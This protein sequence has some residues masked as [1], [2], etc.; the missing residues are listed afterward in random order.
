[1]LSAQRILVLL[2]CLLIGGREVY[3]AG[4]RM[5]DELCSDKVDCQNHNERLWTLPY[6][7]AEEL[8]DEGED[9]GDDE[10]L[11]SH[12][13]SVMQAFVPKL[14][15]TSQFTTVVCAVFHSGQRFLYLRKLRL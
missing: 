9:E 13:V 10:S 15:C 11:S 14:D 8:N 6:E 12:D 5:S 7:T 1:M 3:A 4:I 2:L